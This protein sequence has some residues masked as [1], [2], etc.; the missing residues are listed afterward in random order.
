MADLTPAQQRVAEL[1]ARGLSTKAIARELDVSRR[2]VEQHV[3]DAAA[4][5]PGDG[6]PSYK[7]LRFGLF[8]LLTNE[9]DTQ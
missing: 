7:L 9:E 8:N 5:L 3:A 4:R 2:T 6:R 1:L